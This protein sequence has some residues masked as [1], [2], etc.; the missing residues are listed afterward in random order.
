MK[1]SRSIMPRIQ[2]ERPKRLFRGAEFTRLMTMVLMLVV[3]GMMI[4]SAGNP[5]TWKW[6][7]GKPGHPDQVIAEGSNRDQPQQEQVPLKTTPPSA[8]AG[9]AAVQP[10]APKIPPATGPTDEAEMEAAAAEEDF[11]FIV[12]NSIDVH[13]EEMP[14]YERLARWV[15]N[16]P[17][18]RLASRALPKNPGYGTFVTDPQDFRQPGKIFNFEVHLRMVIKFD[19]KL[20][21]H[22]EDDPHEPVTLYEMWGTTDESR[23]RLLHFLV[24]D[25]PAGLPLGKDV[26]ED[27]R[28][29][30]YFFRVQG[31]EPA[32][33]GLNSR[34]QLAPSF[35]GRIAWKARD[36]GMVLTSSEL[37]WL[38][39]IGGGAVALLIVWVGYLFLGRRS[40]N[41]AYLAT[42]LPPPPS[43]AVENWLD[44]VESGGEE[45]DG[46]LNGHF[47]SDESEH[48]E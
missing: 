20:K 47:S 48:R 31:Y 41:V 44:Q 23:G 22:D 32:K 35:I 28:F 21:F 10:P 7:V 2:P 9:I 38:F 42:D 33:A 8:A 12:D 19:V 1:A 15:I 24:Y 46:G 11:D 43:L 25:P 17:Y 16:Q 13:A 18:Q 29:V 30:G 36:P 39:L 40:R 3:L 27:V 26:R 34:I 6:L 45:P 37:P 5:D 4:K 14:A